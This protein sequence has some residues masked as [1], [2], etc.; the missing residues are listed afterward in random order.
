MSGEIKKLSDEV[1]KDMVTKLHVYHKTGEL[2]KGL[3]KKFIQET[4]Y[5]VHIVEIAVLREAVERFIIPTL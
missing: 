5:D 4:K 2:P 1:L 3:L